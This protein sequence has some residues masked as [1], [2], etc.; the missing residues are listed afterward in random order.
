MLAE[1][2][3]YLNQLTRFD[4]QPIPLAVP[5]RLGEQLLV[6][7]QVNDSSPVFLSLN[8]FADNQSRLNHIGYQDWQVLEPHLAEC[9]RGHHDKIPCSNEAINYLDTSTYGLFI[10]GT[11]VYQA[12]LWESNPN[13]DTRALIKSAQ[14]NQSL[15][16]PVYR[17][18]G[19]GNFL[20]S[21]SIYCLH[22]LGVHQARLS[23]PSP[24][25]QSI[26]LKLNPNQNNEVAVDR[27]VEKELVTGSLTAFLGN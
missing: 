3:Q 24:S 18:L 4:G 26:W 22:Q 13:L 8:L 9:N 19:L 12:L 23:T 17:H 1:Y 7:S 6:S 5:S 11:L 25:S 2:N 10:L 16:K 27:A 15:E 21:A 20:I 14:Q